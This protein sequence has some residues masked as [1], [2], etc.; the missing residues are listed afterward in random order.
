ME[1]NAA[2]IKDTE[3]FGKCQKYQTTNYHTFSAL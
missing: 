2:V 1:N 3:T